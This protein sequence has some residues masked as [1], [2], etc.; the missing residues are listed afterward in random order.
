MVLTAS[1]VFSN[2]CATNLDYS[3]E[4]IDYQAT[5]EDLGDNCLNEPAYVNK[6]FWSSPHNEKDGSVSWTGHIERFIDDKTYQ[7][8]KDLEKHGFAEGKFKKRVEFN[9]NT[10]K[11][12]PIES[13]QGIEE[14]IQLNNGNALAVL[15]VEEGVFYRFYDKK[16]FTTYEKITLDANPKILSKKQKKLYDLVHLKDRD[17]KNLLNVRGLRENLK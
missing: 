17:I 11:Y 8:F 3:A 9:Q 6:H 13:E 5:H 12:D 4:N 10:L 14:Y 16:G 1:S 2:N 7:G 15:A